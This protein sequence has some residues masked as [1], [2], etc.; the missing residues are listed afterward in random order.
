MSQRSSEKALGH[1]FIDIP[2]LFEYA[3]RG[4][5]VHPGRYYTGKSDL[6]LR[7]QV[8]MQMYNCVEVFGGPMTQC[9]EK[10]I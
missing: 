4:C 3:C 8:I 1:R 10:E 2:E 6:S 9:R 5:G 7:I